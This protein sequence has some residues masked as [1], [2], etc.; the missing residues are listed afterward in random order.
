[1]YIESKKVISK[2]IMLALVVLIASTA[3]AAE[4]M[5]H[6]PQESGGVYASQTQEGA[7]PVSSPGADA[8]TVIDSETII[9]LLLICLG[10]LALVIRFFIPTNTEDLF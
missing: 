8:P 10:V 5:T 6:T 1:M 7:V 4:S 9:M 2:L 3:S